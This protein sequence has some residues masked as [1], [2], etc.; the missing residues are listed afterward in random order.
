[1]QWLRKSKALRA[2]L[3][4]LALASVAAG[5]HAA[6]H[7]V[8]A[9]SHGALTA[10]LSQDDDSDKDATARHLECPACRMVGAWSLALVPNATWELHA[11]AD[12]PSVHRPRRA[13]A[14]A[15]DAVARWQQSLK[16]G[17]PPLSR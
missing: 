4:L 16:H 3:L 15:A 11:V 12:D 17:P 2:W 7:V 9:A 1:M 13:A 8:S 6:S 5:F 10:P 14:L